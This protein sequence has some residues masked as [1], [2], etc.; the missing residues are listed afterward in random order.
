M[1][2][3]S[4]YVPKRT[5]IN[6]KR[7]SELA[8]EEIIYLLQIPTQKRSKYEI[9]QLQNYMLKNVDYFK[10]LNEESDGSERIP[11]IV[12]VLSYECFKKDEYIIN[13]G[14]IGNKFYI[15]L[16]GTVSIYKPSPKN[17]YMT[18][19]DYVKYLV[20]I[21]DIE[22]N[23]LKFER[24]QNYN[25][26]ID[27]VKLLLIN[28]NPEKLP[29]SSKKFPLVI[30]EDRF[31]V[32]LGPGTSFGEMALIKNEPRNANIIANEQCILCS[33]DKIDYKKIIKDL[34]EQKINSQLKSFKT[35]FPFFE[36]WPASRCFRILSAFT[37]ENYSKEDYIYRQNS[38]PTHIYIIRKGEFE[39]TCDLNFSIY[40]QFV[41]YIYANSDILFKDMDN[42]GFWKEDKLQ[43]K[44][45][46]SYEINDSP[47]MSLPPIS[48]FTLSHKNEVFPE[49]K[50]V[51]DI[52]KEDNKMEDK[53][54][55]K[56][57]KMEDFENDIKY[58]NKLK[59]RIKICKLEAPQIFGFIEPFE[60]K[61]R[62]CNIRCETSEG[63]VQKIPF[64]EFLQLMPKD[65]KNRFILEE[66]I[67]NRKKELL[68]QLKNGTLAKLS[69]NY[70]K[71]Q[72][73]DIDIY[74]SRNLDKVS[75][76][77][78][79]LLVRSKSI[80]S[81]HNQKY[82]TLS[83]NYKI[84][85]ESNKKTDKNEVNNDKGNKIKINT[86]ILYGFKKALFNYS[87]KN[88]TGKLQ[89]LFGVVNN[90]KKKKE[91]LNNIKLN[92]SNSVR[93]VKYL[94]Q[95]S[96]MNILPT[97]FSLEP[98]P[99]TVGKN[100]IDY[101]NRRLIK[102]LNINNKLLYVP[103]SKTESKYLPNINTKTIKRS[104]SLLSQQL[105][106]LEK[107]QRKNKQNQSTLFR[108]KDFKD[109]VE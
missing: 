53:N 25:S 107:I 87:G 79:N 19:Y 48:R 60:L 91:M 94:S 57:S 45:H 33:V 15:L 72:M 6:I 55:K 35:D 77:D 71:P 63:E 14:E 106:S 66:K 103:S 36:E 4:K 105:Q 24:V 108:K 70:K 80:I 100:Y 40:E 86:N 82:S 92:G 96:V 2:K 89:Y 42:P 38:L 99:K 56:I 65:K 11:K 109:D 43:K 51:D 41:E 7:T 75:I 98:N 67:L 95:Q 68:E 3:K 13:F 23:L 21:R 9:K 78:S 85:S 84:E 17:M 58:Q 83:N 39:V 73:L 93:M 37:T 8:L 76:K 74:P 22:K 50:K 26:S 29:Y 28:Y 101:S 20:Q 18:L 54:L 81:Y 1:K 10:K 46:T 52:S 61:K 102:K 47:F 44:I 59:R 34:E 62:F 32:K 16:S 88:T 5:S 49:L 27:R 64:I 31:V 90:K 97:K 104:F 12:Q 69:F 30:E